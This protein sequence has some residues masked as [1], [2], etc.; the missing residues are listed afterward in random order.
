MQ[1][2]ALSK[3]SALVFLCK[4]NMVTFVKLVLLARVLDSFIDTANCPRIVDQ[5]D[6]EVS[7]SILLTL[8]DLILRISSMNPQF[9]SK[10]E[11]TQHTQELPSIRAV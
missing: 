10:P 3:V 4:S 7:K 5:V 1:E 6:W 11:E 8:K 9:Q 2:M